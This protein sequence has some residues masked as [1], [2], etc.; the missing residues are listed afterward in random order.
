MVTGKRPYPEDDLMALLDL[1]LEQD[2]PDP[3][4]MVKDLPGDLRRFIITCCHRNRNQRYQSISH[5]MEDLK[6]LSKAL[7]PIRGDTPAQN[8]RM[9]T[10]VMIYSDEHQLK[11]NRIMEDFSNQVR[12]LGVVLRATDFNDD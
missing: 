3:A 1:H 7:R 2:I 8:Q 10:F 12:E 5:A 9:A 6:P 4:E 11:L